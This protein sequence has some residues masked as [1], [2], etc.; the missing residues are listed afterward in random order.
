MSAPK[1]IF[2]TLFK[3]PFANPIG[4]LTGID[5]V[6]DM[7]FPKEIKPPKPAPPPPP[8]PPPPG[9]VPFVASEK[10]SAGPVIGGQSDRDRARSRSSLVIDLNIGSSGGGSGLQ[11]PR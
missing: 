11:I 3:D 4:T 7:L 9:A 8:P 2:E 5:P 10:Q 6:G 1:K